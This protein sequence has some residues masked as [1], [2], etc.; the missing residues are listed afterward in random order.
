MDRYFDSVYATFEK[1]ITDIGF[2]KLMMNVVAGLRC[3]HT[4]ITLPQ[5]RERAAATHLMLLPFEVVTVNNKAYISE[6]YNSLLYPGLEIQTINDTPADQI[7]QKMLDIIPSDGYNTTNK[8]QLLN[9]GMFR[10]AYALLM[11]PS[12]SFVI[13][14]IDSSGSPVRVE[15]AA[16]APDFNRP[17]ARR[18]NQISWLIRNED[19]TGVLSLRSLEL[20]S[21]DFTRR[22]DSFFS[23]IHDRNINRLIID[24]RDNGGGNNVNVPVL[25]S[26]LAER[27]FYHLRK[28]EISRQPLTYRNHISNVSDYDN[29]RTRRAE[30]PNYEFSQYPGLRMREAVSANHF[31]GKLILLVNGATISA[32]SEFVALVKGNKR[33]I[34]IG[35]ETGGCYYGSTGGSYLSLVLPNSQ[36][37]ARIPA[38]RIFITVP[39]DFKQQPPGR[40]VLPDYLISYSITDI[41]NGRDRSM[42]MAL[43]KESAVLQ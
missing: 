39:E 8:Y 10:R 35:E 43:H 27:P 7:L 21:R 29:L 14:G 16:I 17:P 9:R 18:E 6:S 38:V 24:L 26:Y 40:G 23:Q 42:E 19:S 37:R 34:I 25:Y 3:V 28:T 32:A 41:L 33:G 30:D 4:S 11:P 22:I 2:Y 36:L 5:D 15:V 1:P 20:N 13:G 31:D 12:D